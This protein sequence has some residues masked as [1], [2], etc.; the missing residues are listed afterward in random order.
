MPDAT[1][2]LDAINR[3]DD[4]TAAA[5]ILPFIERSPLVAGRVARRRP[6]RDAAALADAVAAEIAALT[7]DER[8]AFFR[9][10]PELAPVAPSAMTAHSKSEQG[11]L[12]LAAPDAEIA[13]L[14]A[15][16]NRRYRER[17]G[18][19]FIIALARHRDLASVLS[20]FAQRLGATREAEMA[21]ASEEI[22]AVSRARILAALGGAGAPASAA[23]DAVS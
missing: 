20:A 3:G 17:F 22:A 15:D 13:G 1:H 21:S 12:G 11:R 10:H 6:F 7:E 18:F 5:R 19:P 23:T 14:L 8:L 2:L 9:G 16:L 4:A